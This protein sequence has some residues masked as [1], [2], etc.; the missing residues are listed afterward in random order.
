MEVRVIADPSLW[1][2]P[3]LQFGRD[4]GS[5]ADDSHFQSY[6]APLPRLLAT[7]AQLTVD[8][9]NRAPFARQ[10]S[11]RFPVRHRTDLASCRSY[12]GREHRRSL[13]K[14]N[15]NTR[16]AQSSASKATYRKCCCGRHRIGGKP[17]ECPSRHW[18]F[19]RF[20]SNHFAP[21]SRTDKTNSQAFSRS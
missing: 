12:G 9:A 6:V 18:A 15:S 1:L 10:A 14:R 19:Q 17:S 20:V 13:A 16:R 21:G 2:V 7:D 11:T 4:N 8:P 5:A 3:V